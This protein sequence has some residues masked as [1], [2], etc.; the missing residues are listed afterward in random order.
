MIDYDDIFNRFIEGTKRQFAHDRSKTVGASEVFDCHRKAYFKKTG[1]EKDKDLETS[2]GATARG[3]LIENF[4]VVPAMDYLPGDAYIVGAGADQKTFIDEEWKISAT[5]DGLVTGVSKDALSLYGVEDI[6]SD[7]F[8]QE[9]KSIDPRVSLQQAKE[10]HKGQA[11][12]QMGLIREQT[13]FKP[14]YAIILYFNAS[15]LDMIDKFVVK[16]DHKIFQNGKARAKKVFEASSA[17]DLKPEGKLSGACNYCEFTSICTRTNKI[18]MPLEGL[19]NVDDR[20]A[21][22]Q[23]LDLAVKHEEAKKKRDEADDEVKEIGA[24]IKD[25]LKRFNA[26]KLKETLPDGRTVTVNY[27]WSSGKSKIDLEEMRADGI[28][29]DSYKVT[30]EGHE[31]LTVKVK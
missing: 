27:T 11:I 26:R 12:I 9:I 31:M 10:I 2:W 14:E 23:F 19:A 7:C 29:V 18:A 21:L 1:A 17:E 16:Y 22:D 5:P 20:Q 13:E 30:G 25:A 3:D 8:V 24:G 4:F 15:F 6:G 28:D